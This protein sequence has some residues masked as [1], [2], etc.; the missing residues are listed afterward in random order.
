MLV[1]ILKDPS[2]WET[3]LKKCPAS[4][5]F[6]SLQWKEV[7]QK[8]FPYSAHYIT[9]RD[10][11]DSIIGVCPGFIRK[12]MHMK[13][14]D[15]TPHSDYGGP[16]FNGNNIVEFYGHLKKYFNNLS[17]AE[18]LT[19]SKCFLNH[20][21]F[22]HNYVFP[23]AFI[24]TGTGVIEID[25][26]QTSSDFLWN[27][28][29]SNHRRYWIN[30]I[31]RQNIHARLADSISDL[32]EFY[33]LYYKNMNSINVSPRPYDF[34][35]NMWK[36]LYPK[37]LRIWLLEKNDSVGG[38]LVLKQNGKS[39]CCHVG[40]DREK[41][42]NIPVINYLT[43]K[44]IKLAESDGYR[45]VSLGTT[46]N[47]RKNI[48]FSKK[49]AIGGRFKQQKKMWYPLNPRGIGIIKTV[50]LLQNVSKRFPVTI[51][52]SLKNKTRI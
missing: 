27:N 40:I 7:I 14:F 3:F 11:N 31:E 8:S 47:D 35:Q 46:P 4:T 48:H 15:S 29:Y 18:H 2:E 36:Y 42:K 24:E 19:F 50:K 6:H 20:D 45:M 26:K 49:I 17:N 12:Q 52:K 21:F 1:D 34:I 22:D 51:Q 30:K 41:S 16:L 44:E 39:Y 37:H 10:D 13:F 38:L 25:L 33:N 9:I 23:T 28:V 32:K 5:V 43:W